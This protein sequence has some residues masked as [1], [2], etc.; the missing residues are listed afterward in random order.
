MQLG[1]SRW[2]CR[3]YTVWSNPPTSWTSM[4]RVTAA[5]AFPVWPEGPSQ[6]YWEE[7]NTYKHLTCVLCWKSG[8]RAGNGRRDSTQYVPGQQ[9]SQLRAWLR[10]GHGT[11][12]IT[13]EKRFCN[14]TH[15]HSTHS[16][17]GFSDYQGWPQL[18]SESAHSLSSF[19][20]FLQLFN[21]FH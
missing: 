21:V 9:R 19:L 7:N 6:C 17:I 10:Y 2:F 5:K 4:L 18:L 1:T 12:M 20:W 3:V 15:G 14:F 16:S 11:F 13:I 8:F